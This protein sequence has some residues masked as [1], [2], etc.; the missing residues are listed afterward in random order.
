MLFVSADRPEKISTIDKKSDFD[1]VLLSDSKLEAAKAF[2][3]AFHLDDDMLKMFTK[4][5]IDLEEASGETHHGLPVPS[6]FILDT[7]GVIRFSYVDPNYKARVDPDL[8]V[9]A[10][11]ASLR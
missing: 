2:G 3:I 11:K 6:V 5:G 7:E 8:L 9:A 4:Y 10:A 1:Y